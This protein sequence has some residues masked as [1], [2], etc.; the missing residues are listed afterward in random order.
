[1]SKAKLNEFNKGIQ[2]A[3]EYEEALSGGDRA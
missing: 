3:V 2:G 1:M